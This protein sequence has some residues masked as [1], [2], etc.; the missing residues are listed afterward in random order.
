M[1]VTPERDVPDERKRLCQTNEYRDRAADRLL[2]PSADTVRDTQQQ[3]K[4]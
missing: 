2:V 1:I 3:T 4:Q